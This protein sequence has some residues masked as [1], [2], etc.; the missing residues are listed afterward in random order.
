[1]T[2]LEKARPF[3]NWLSGRSVAELPFAPRKRNAFDRDLPVQSMGIEEAKSADHHHVGG[4]RHLLFLGQE[5]LVA[6]NVLGAELI[7]W[8]AEVDWSKNPNDPRSE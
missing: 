8:F 1:M 4:R 7:G 3:G 6:A 5:Q 2:K